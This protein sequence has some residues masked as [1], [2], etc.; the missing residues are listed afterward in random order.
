M[1]VYWQADNQ[2]GDRKEKEVQDEG[3]KMRKKRM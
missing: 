2:L 3:E 1:R